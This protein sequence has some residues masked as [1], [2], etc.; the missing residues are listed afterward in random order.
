MSLVTLASTVL[1]QR[2]ADEAFAWHLDWHFAPLPT[3]A[4][5]A[6]LTVRLGE[7]VVPVPD[8]PDPAVDGPL[9]RW[10]RGDALVL[11]HSSGLTAQVDDER[12]DVDTARS[13]PGDWRP[14]RQALFSALSWWF[15]RRG[16]V[17]LHGALVG[18]DA[19]GAMVVL[20]HTG[21]GKSTIASAALL[22]GW[23]VLGDDLLLVRHGE[24]GVE[25]FGVPK[26]V[27]VGAELAPVLGHPDAVPLAG[28]QRGRVVL[29]PEV[30]SVGWRPVRGVLVAAHD[31]GPG[32]VT[33]LPTAD[34]VTALAQ[35]FLEA[36]R[37]AV[38]RRRL[39]TLARVAG[40]GTTRLA[41]ARDPDVR[42]ARAGALLDAAWDAAGAVRQ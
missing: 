21:A 11:L 41:H 12:L 1:D 28:D 29:P 5:P 27:M 14:T 35:A 17:M 24:E 40:T 25:A 42:L 2:A 38:L 8:G 32:R 16:L 10:D 9:R 37:P 3:G 19:S 20:G 13:D 39:A 22:H 23:Q 36:R 30:L 31:D 34:G 15:E 26:R 4:A 33:D 6:D 18:R 7:R